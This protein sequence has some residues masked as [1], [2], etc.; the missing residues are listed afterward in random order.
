MKFNDSID[1]YVNIS[2]IKKGYKDQLIYYYNKG[3]GS[4]S[5]IAGV[6]ISKGLVSTIEKRYS[7]LGGVLPISKQDIEEKKGKK[8]T[9][10]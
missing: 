9:L 2:I 1:T 5:E 10:I 6:V 7:K 4:T 8:W 3:I